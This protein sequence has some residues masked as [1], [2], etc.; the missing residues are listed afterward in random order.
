[1]KQSLG[2]KVKVIAVCGAVGLA[3][4]CAKPVQADMI[5]DFENGTD[6]GF[7]RK[8][9]NDGTS[10]TFPIFNI[11]GSKRMQVLRDGDFQEAERVTFN[12][13]DS[14]YVAMSAASTDEANY[15]LSYDWYVD[16]SQF[17]TGAGTFLQL[18]T[19]VNT[20]NGY[21]AQDFPGSG[22]D[23]E[24]NSTQLGSGGVYSGTVTETFS[25][26]GFD[27]PDGQTF[28]RFGLILN[29]DGAN[30]SVYYDNISIRSALAPPTA[31][32][33]EP[34]TWAMMGIGLGFLGFI[35]RRKKKATAQ[36]AVA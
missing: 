28:F 6:E 16:T 34:G 24:L 35:G 5:F 8:F 11:G 3:V 15:V 30:Q 1:M 13:S 19:Y 10:E 27:L 2:Q 17:G 23:V 26:K 36:A 32:T 9:T 4:L 12:P 18:G 31:A 22:K 25:Q 29:G 21:Y 33:P 14:Q 7:G 20:G